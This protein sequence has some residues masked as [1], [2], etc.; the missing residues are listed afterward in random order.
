MAYDDARHRVLLFGGNGATTLGDLWSW[1]G[2]RWTRLSTSGPPP[3]DDA[4]LVFDSW[5]QRLVLFGGRSGQTLLADTWEWDGTSWSQKGGAGPEAR[6]HAV[7]AFDAERGVVRIYGGVGT[8]DVPRTEPGNGTA[9]R[10]RGCPRP[11]PP[12]AAP[13]TWRM[14][15]HASGP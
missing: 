1:D 9:P 11:V 4:V 3:R 13:T 14:T 12:T 7:G 5:R 2:T 6:L 15:P 10:G 8:D